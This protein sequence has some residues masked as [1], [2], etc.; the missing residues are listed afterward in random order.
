MFIFF[1]NLHRILILF[2]RIC[3]VHM[4]LHENYIQI[5][6]CF[7]LLVSSRLKRRRKFKKLPSFRMNRTRSACSHVEHMEHNL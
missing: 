4:D 3:P 6:T 2:I 5:F 7:A 1:L